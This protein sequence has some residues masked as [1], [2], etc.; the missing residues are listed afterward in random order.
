MNPNPLLLPDTASLLRVVDE[1]SQHHRVN[2]IPVV[3]VSG[4]LV[5]I[6]SRSDIVKFYSSMLRE[7]K[8][9]YSKKN[10]RIIR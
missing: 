1:F 5:G 10:R 8:N 3:D 7:A 9:D 2:P 4:K 6:I